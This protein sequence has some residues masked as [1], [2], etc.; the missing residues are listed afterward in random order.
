MAG[1]QKQAESYKADL[2]SSEPA[3]STPH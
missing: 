3:E 1:L 2:K